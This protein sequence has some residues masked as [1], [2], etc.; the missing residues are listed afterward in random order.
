[1]MRLLGLSFLT[2][3]LVS[4]GC[5]SKPAT[6]IVKGKV[7]VGGKSPL[8]GG[9]ITFEL[10]SDPKLVG[11]GVI[12][13]DGSYE[14]TEAPV[15]E[16]RVRIDNQNLNPGAR[17]NNL[18]GAGMGPGMGMPGMKGA[19]GK[20]PGFGKS[21]DVGKAGAGGPPKGLEVGGE[22]N[23]EGSS[24]AGAKYMKID[25]SYGTEQSTLKA[26]VKKGTNEGVD[27]DVK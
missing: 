22:M 8:T 23:A 12:K 7:T 11:S 15:G 24:S 21:K 3:A 6:A 10:A 4:A 17:N 27:F 19:V 18:P 26:T 25:P 9:S 16:C 14:V 20:G 5:S 13:A 2:V 1:M